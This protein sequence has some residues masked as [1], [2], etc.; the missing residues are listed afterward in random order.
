MKNP[1]A[2]TAEQNR[3][4]LIPVNAPYRQTMLADEPGL[5]LRL[6]PNEH[7]QNLLRKRQLAGGTLLNP[8]SALWEATSDLLVDATIT[9]PEQDQPTIRRILI[10]AGD[11][12]CEVRLVMC[13]SRHK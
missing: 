12:E 1:G 4:N 6:V 5:R 2:S 11:T 13:M 8:R 9:L 7:S 10:R 3:F